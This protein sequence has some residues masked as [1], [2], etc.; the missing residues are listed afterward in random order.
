MYDL[1]TYIMCIE[2]NSVKFL[3]KI[4]ML[5]KCMMSIEVNNIVLHLK[6]CLHNL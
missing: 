2:Q 6:I 1:E 5:P 4:F 3:R